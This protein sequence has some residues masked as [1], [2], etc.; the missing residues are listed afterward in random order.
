MAYPSNALGT[1]ETLKDELGIAAGENAHDA[2]LE[3][4]AG[5]AT[6][7][8]ESWCKRN[9]NRATVTNERVAGFGTPR[10]VLARTP[11]ESVT[12]ITLDG[13]TID[14][15]EYYVEDAGAGFVFR[16]NSCWD[17][18]QPSA[19]QRG[20]VA[21]EK[22]YLVTYVG[23]YYLP[24]SAQRNL[25]YA[26]EQAFVVAVVSMFRSKGKYQQLEAE[27]VDGATRPWFDF[28]LPPNAKQ[29]LDAHKRVTL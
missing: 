29:L 7:A 14:A 16:S 22:K 27:T 23:G 5:T 3:R 15:S 8:I 1:L 19:G 4:A 10:L 6:E 25:P 12:S 17:W 21:E 11:I 9:F 2:W 20:Y 24:G 28:V 13:V 26:I 18:T